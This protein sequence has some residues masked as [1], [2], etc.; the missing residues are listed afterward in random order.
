LAIPKPEK[1]RVFPVLYQWENPW[2]SRDLQ[3]GRAQDFELLERR[4]N[5]T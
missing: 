4:R 3:W 5:P 2:F 1:P